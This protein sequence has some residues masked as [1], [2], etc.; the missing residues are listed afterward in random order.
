MTITL[1]WIVV[2]VIV[3]EKRQIL[4]IVISC[5]TVGE[6]HRA[7]NLVA[8]EEQI[9]RLK[10]VVYKKWL[11]VGKRDTAVTNRSGEQKRTGTNRTVIKRNELIQQLKTAFN[12]DDLVSLCFQLN[13]AYDDL[14]GDNRKR[15]FLS[16]IDQLERENRIQELI[17][18]CKQERPQY[19]WDGFVSS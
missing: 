12:N 13:V 14:S 19:N 18:L 16:L 17:E 3:A 11:D 7:K 2:K 1:R 4:D 8:C 6:V 5:G 9:A 15:R 10:S